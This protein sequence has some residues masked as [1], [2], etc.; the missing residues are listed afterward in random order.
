MLMPG[1]QNLVNGAGSRPAVLRHVQVQNDLFLERKARPK[2]PRRGWESPAPGALF[3]IT[4]K[5]RNIY[6]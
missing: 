2:E 3:V 4:P 6:K 5:K 1:C